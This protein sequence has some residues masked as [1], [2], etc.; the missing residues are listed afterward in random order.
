MHELS[1]AESLV[2]A[3]SEAAREE[4]IAR[5][6]AVHLRL[7]K[8]AGVASESLLFC[9]EVAAKGTAL[10]GSKLVIEPVAGHAIEIRALECPDPDDGS[11][12]R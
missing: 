1:I 11:G 8:F 12:L 3:A 7:G 4:G 2:E 10:E 9:Y 6:T 5:V